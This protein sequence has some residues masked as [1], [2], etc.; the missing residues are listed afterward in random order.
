MYSILF[1]SYLVILCILVAC[2]LTGLDIA[3][4][5]QSGFENRDLK[6]FEGDWLIEP[7]VYKITIL[8]HILSVF[9]SK[10]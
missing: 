8:E 4:A 7:Y 9:L 5:E 3:I 10:K 6:A 2:S 1:T